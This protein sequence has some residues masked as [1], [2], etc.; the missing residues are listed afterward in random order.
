MMAQCRSIVWTD[1]Y[2]WRTWFKFG[3]RHCLW[4]WSSALSVLCQ[5]LFHFEGIRCYVLTNFQKITTHEHHP[6]SS[7][8]IQSLQLNQRHKAS[9]QLISFIWVVEMYLKFT[10]FLIKHDDLVKLFCSKIPINLRRN[11]F[12]H[13]WAS[14]WVSN[15]KFISH[16]VFMYWNAFSFQ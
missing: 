8:L 13:I 16:S 15:T 5:M 1:F 2:Y 6:I 9:E 11:R 7:D 10:L 12:E 3:R 4:C 14:S